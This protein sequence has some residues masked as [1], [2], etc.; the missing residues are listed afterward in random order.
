ME[1]INNYQLA[2]RSLNQKIQ[3]IQDR[4]INQEKFFRKSA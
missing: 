3:K 2:Q 1:G 4:E